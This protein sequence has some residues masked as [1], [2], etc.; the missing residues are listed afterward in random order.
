MLK[1]FIASLAFVSVQAL[2]ASHDHHARHNMVVYG[3]DEVF[4]SHIVYKQPHNFQV[5]LRIN[6]SAPVLD[7]YRTARSEHPS[8]TYIFLLD[9]SDISQIGSA[10]SLKGSLSRS[11]EEG[12]QVIAPEV[13]LDRNDF[14]VIFFQELPLSLNQN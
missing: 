1:S 5:I 8:D 14:Q 7:A 10:T 6:F 12:Q 11:N 3:V 13:T 4:A 9:P 2:A